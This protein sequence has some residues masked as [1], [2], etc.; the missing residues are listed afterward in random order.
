[1]AGVLVASEVI[2]ERLFPQAMLNG[3]YWNALVGGFMARNRP[4]RPKPRPGC[5]VC[6]N[7]AFRAQY[8]RFWED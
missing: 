1:M 4:Q 6:G 2:K 3:Y 7:T 5:S 8:Q